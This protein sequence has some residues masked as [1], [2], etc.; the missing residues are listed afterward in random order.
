MQL[1][2]SHSTAIMYSS[3]NVKSLTLQISVVIRGGDEAHSTRHRLLLAPVLRYAPRR[4][5]PPL[6]QPR[7]LADG[8]V[9]AGSAATLK[10]VQHVT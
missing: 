7:L 4:Y 2:V 3:V 1:N 6:A 9:V 8:P 10:R 5:A